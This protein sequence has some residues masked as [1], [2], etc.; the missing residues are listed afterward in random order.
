M[1]WIYEYTTTGRR[2]MYWFTSSYKTHSRIS[3]LQWIS[4]WIQYLLCVLLSSR[5]WRKIRSSMPI[6]S[7]LSF[8]FVL[9]EKTIGCH[10]VA[11]ACQNIDWSLSRSIL[12]RS[13]W[14]NGHFNL[15]T[16][17][18]SIL[19]LFPHKTRCVSLENKLYIL[20]FSI[21]VVIL[22][23]A[24]FLIFFYNVRTCR[25]IRLVILRL[26]CYSFYRR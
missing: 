17:K 24:Q 25:F 7:V 5:N 4:N 14:E 18:C 11:I 1:R 9:R 10:P 21:I 3:I 20:I 23:T 15:N 22:V 26:D 19:R 12:P 13:S 16:C 8:R 2:S 6:G